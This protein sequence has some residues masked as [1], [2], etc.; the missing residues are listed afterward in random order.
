M[1]Y[2]AK[3]SSIE[4]IY[5]Y[6]IQTLVGNISDIPLGHCLT[7][8]NVSSFKAKAKQIFANA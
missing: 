7:N 1:I 4:I 6:V 8:T 2:L 3:P 5:S